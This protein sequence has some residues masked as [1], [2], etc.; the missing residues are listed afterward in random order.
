[1]FIYSFLYIRGQQIFHERNQR[2]NNSGVSGLKVTVAVIQFCC[3]RVKQ[4]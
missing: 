1:M 3:C 2:V 4:S